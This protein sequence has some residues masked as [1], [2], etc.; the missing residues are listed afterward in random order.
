ME[1]NDGGKLMHKWL[2]PL[3]GS[4]VQFIKTILFGEL[5]NDHF[6]ENFFQ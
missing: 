6:I 3:S 5:Y 1:E 4:C 2:T